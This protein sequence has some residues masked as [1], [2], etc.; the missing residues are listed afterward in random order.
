[1]LPRYDYLLRYVCFTALPQRGA[2][3]AAGAH[4]A[5]SRFLLLGFLLAPFT[6]QV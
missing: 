6:L 4:M 2:R 5:Y 1:M 3:K